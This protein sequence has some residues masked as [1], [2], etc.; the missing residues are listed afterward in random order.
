MLEALPQLQAQWCMA[1]DG[2]RESIHDLETPTA[3]RQVRMTA[4]RMR[5]N[6]DMRN[7]EREGNTGARWQETVKS[8]ISTVVAVDEMQNAGPH[9]RPG[10]KAAPTLA[11]LKAIPDLK[12]KAQKAL[13]CAPPRAPF[14]HLLLHSGQ[15]QR[16]LPAFC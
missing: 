16:L 7:L 15:L 9:R 4:S 8:V 3:M 6:L 13:M 11:A 5:L 12:D 2:L 1:A 10:S 14:T